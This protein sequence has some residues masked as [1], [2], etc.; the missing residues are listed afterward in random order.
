MSSAPRLFDSEALSQRR[1]RAALAPAH[2]L[3][4]QAAAEVRERLEDIN[5]VFTA[6]AVIGPQAEE[7]SRWLGIENTAVVLPDAEILPFKKGSHD[8]IVHALS[9]HWANDPVGQLVQMRLALQPDGLMIACCFGGRSLS[10]LRAVLAE[11]EAKIRS[12]LSPRVAPMG[13]IREL[14]SLLQRAGFALPVVDAS[15][16]EVTYEN[17]TALMRDLRAMGE[18]NVLAARERGFFRRDVLALAES[19]YRQ[20]FPAE[21]DRIRATAEIVFLTGWAPSPDQPQAL[22]PGSAKMRLADALQ[23]EEHSAEDATPR[24]MQKD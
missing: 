11:A 21:G 20:H 17:A 16:T 22:R 7:W 19:L 2:F 12:G 8:L 13:E 9:L 15:L 5:R 24:P 10:E 6:P 18:T 1:H 23:V 3:Q 4:R 14:G